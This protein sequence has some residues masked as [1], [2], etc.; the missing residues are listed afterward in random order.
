M[1]LITSI[2]PLRTGTR[3]GSY[4]SV[5]REPLGTSLTRVETKTSSHA[6]WQSQL[7]S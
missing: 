5:R 4:S 3:Q 7:T 2:W 1:R 6:S